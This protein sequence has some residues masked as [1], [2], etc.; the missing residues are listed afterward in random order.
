MFIQV[1]DSDGQPSLV[2]L[3]NVKA[4][5]KLEGGAVIRYVD[6]ESDE[7]TTTFRTIKARIRKATGEDI[8]Q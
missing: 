5:A 4:V 2:N 1:E 8:P 3:D 7:P 6:G